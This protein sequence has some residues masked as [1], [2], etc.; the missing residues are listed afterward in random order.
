MNL[1]GIWAN[2]ITIHIRERPIRPDVRPVADAFSFPGSLL[3]RPWEQV[4]L[5]LPESLTGVV[6]CSIQKMFDRELTWMRQ[7]CETLLTYTFYS[8]FSFF[9]LPFRHT[10]HSFLNIPALV[11]QNFY[12]CLSF[13]IHECH[14]DLIN[15]AVLQWRWGDFE[16]RFADLGWSLRNVTNWRVSLS[17]LGFWLN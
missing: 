11:R 14:C 15:Y 2:E 6:F 10:I 12:S 13:L 16:V 17:T 4:W 3:A 7:G 9:P 1:K 5:P 8:L